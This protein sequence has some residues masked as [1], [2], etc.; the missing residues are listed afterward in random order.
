MLKLTLKFIS[1]L[2]FHIAIPVGSSLVT[3]ISHVSTVLIL[4]THD[5]YAVIVLGYLFISQGSLIAM[6][7]IIMIRFVYSSKFYCN[8]ALKSLHSILK[9]LP[10][11]VYTLRRQIDCVLQIKCKPQSVENSNQYRLNY[12]Q[13]NIT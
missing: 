11:L 10:F 8:T 9:P 6:L 1:I 3:R 5:F 4:K 12:L 2:E 7:A 13:A